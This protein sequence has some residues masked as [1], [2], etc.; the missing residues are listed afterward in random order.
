MTLTEPKWYQYVAVHL[1][2]EGKVH[3]TVRCTSGTRDNRRTETVHYS[4]DETHADVSVVVWGNKEALQPTKIDPGT[5]N[6]PFQLTLPSHC[7]PTLKNII[8]NIEYKLLGIVSSQVNEYKIET[9]LVV[10]TVIDLNKQPNLLLPV[11]QSAVVNITTFC[12]CNAGEAYLT[13]KVPK[14]GFCIAR[15]RIPVT[16]E[17]RNGSTQ[18]ISAVVEVAQS[19]DCNNR[20]IHHKE[21]NETIGSFSFQIQPSG[22]ETKTI[23]FDVPPSIAL[24]FVTELITLSHSVRVWVDYSVKIGEDIKP[25]ISIPVVIGN[26]PFHGTGQPAP[27]DTDELQAN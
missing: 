25:P 26:V 7:P 1:L 13:L 15:E 8:G 16:L 17:C 11:D 5:F 6:F 3:W 14:T 10:G 2:G 21:L 27:V 23:E 18:Q 20:G 22:Y 9:P 19:V 24:G 12:C 4:A